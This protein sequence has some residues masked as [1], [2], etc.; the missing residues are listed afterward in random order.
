VALGL[1]GVCCLGVTAAFAQDPEPDKP[2][3]KERK[4]EARQPGH[5]VAAEPPAPIDHGERSVTVPGRQ[6]DWQG[7]GIIVIPGRRYSLTAKGEWRAGTLC[8]RTLADGLGAHKIGCPNIATKLVQGYT[9]S[10]LIAKVGETGKPFFVGNELQFTAPAE[11]VLY[12]RINEPPPWVGNNSGFQTVSIRPLDP[13]SGEP[14]QDRGVGVVPDSP[15]T[16]AVE[17]IGEPAVVPAVQSRRWAVV[18]GIS[19]YKDSR[20]PSLRFAAKDAVAFHDWLVAPDGGRYPPARVKLLLD[21]AATAKGIR[22]ALFSWLGGTIEEDVVTLY[23]AG[24]GSPDTPA[25]PENLSLLPHDAQYDSIAATGFPMWDIETALERFIHASRVVVIADA[26]H[27]GG[28][29]AAF[30]VARRSSPETENNAISAG[31]QTLAG[32]GDGVAVISAADD[33]QFSYEGEQFGGG[34]GAFTHFL[35]EGLKGAADYSKDGRVTLGELIPFLSE[36]VR[37]A[38]KNAQS[39][40]VAGRFDPAMSLGR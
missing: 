32:I 12:L 35:L 23:F 19:R 36:H 3:R 4:R 33:E 14:V 6:N 2:T 8:G 38:T 24:H 21:E 15:A 37:R 22:E 16:D 39:P 7:S 26:C 18:I 11:G 9:A 17:A 10:A 13:S 31:L 27:S 1:V 20:I 30:D 25:T 34:H 40:T 29:G 28:V 5:T